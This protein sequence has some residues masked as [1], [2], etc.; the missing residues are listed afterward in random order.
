[1]TG[2]K[3]LITLVVSV[4][5]IWIGGSLA[6]VAGLDSWPERG[7]FGDLFGSVNALFSG[8]AFAGLLYTIH[9]QSQELSLQREELALQRKEM[10]LSREELANQAR[11][12]RALFLATVGQIRVSALQ[13]E[14][15][16]LEM[17]SLQYNPGARAQWVALIRQSKEQMN[18]IA[19]QVEAQANAG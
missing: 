15:Q 11:V 19:A 6:I 2:N 9:L 1:M 4:V 8:L 7:Q 18:A 12:Q 13:A 16:A 3:L 5:V 17:D 10:S 14:V